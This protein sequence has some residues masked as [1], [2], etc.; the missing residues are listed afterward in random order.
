MT[1]E[2]CWVSLGTA[3]TVFETQSLEVDG[4]A[5]SAESPKKQDTPQPSASVNKSQAQ[6]PLNTTPRATPRAIPPPVL[7]LCLRCSIFACPA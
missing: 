3:L 6:K 2:S 4:T 7:I 1:A 5:N